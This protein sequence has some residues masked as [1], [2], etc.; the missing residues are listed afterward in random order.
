MRKTKRS[1]VPPFIDSWYVADVS[2]VVDQLSN[3]N[4]ATTRL[5]NA[6]LRT[7]TTPRR[8]RESSVRARLLRYTSASNGVWVGKLGSLERRGRISGERLANGVAGGRRRVGDSLDFE[9]SAS[10]LL[11]V[12][13]A[14]E[15]I[16]IAATRRSVSVLVARAPSATNSRRTLL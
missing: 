12:A 14:R 4:R 2:D 7:W 16:A 11:L 1:N 8:W 6:M 3:V 5:P 13:R 15:R 9:T 10:H